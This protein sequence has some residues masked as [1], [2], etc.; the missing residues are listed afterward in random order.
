MKK[1][2][3]VKRKTEKTK[4]ELDY[5]TSKMSLTY[6]LFRYIWISAKSVPKAFGTAQHLF[7]EYLIVKCH[8]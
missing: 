5:E 2:F 1:T 8:I 6:L 7:K 3:S 4:N